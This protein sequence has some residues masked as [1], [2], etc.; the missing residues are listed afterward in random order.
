MR[1]PAVTIA[2]SLCMGGCTGRDLVLAHGS[3]WQRYVYDSQRDAPEMLGSLV[4]REQVC[5]G[6]E[7]DP[8]YS[9]LD[10]ND[11][12]RFLERQQIHV[13]VERPRTD[14][15]YLVVNDGRTRKPARLRVAILQN[16]EDA[17]RELAE[18]LVQ[19]GEGSW[20]VHRSNLAVLGPVGD[21]THDL[22]FA[23]EIGL[24]CW[25]V[26]TVRGRKDTF[27][28]PGAYREL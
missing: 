23:A 9:P 1:R 15:A 3:H 13:N 7:L 14:L 16:A 28:I 18:A 20:G 11:L 6:R 10:E 22:V 17:G 21:P 12:L 4:F 5:A 25:G 26:F 2:F 19:H 8:E 24:V 27:V